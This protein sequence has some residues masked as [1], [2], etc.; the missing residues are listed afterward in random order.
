MSNRTLIKF[1]ETTSKYKKD[2]L[3]YVDGFVNIDGNVHAIVII[4]SQ[5]EITNPYKWWRFLND[6]FKNKYVTAPTEHI[7]IEEI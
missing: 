3:G 6:N 2:Q 5:Q 4:F 1:T 7:E